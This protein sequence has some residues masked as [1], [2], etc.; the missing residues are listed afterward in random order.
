MKLLSGNLLNL[1]FYDFSALIAGISS[2]PEEV[3]SNLFPVF[4]KIVS[5]FKQ[6]FVS[7]H[8]VS[9]SGSHALELKV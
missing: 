7:L 8:S 2:I 4:D 1:F 6:Y 9:F 3:Q 5:L